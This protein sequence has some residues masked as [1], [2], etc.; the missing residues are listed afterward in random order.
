[1]EGRSFGNI[2]A[3]IIVSLST[4]KIPNHAG[5]CIS[6]TNFGLAVNFTASG[7][8]LN[9]KSD[10]F[11]DILSLSSAI[12]IFTFKG[13]LGLDSLLTVPGTSAQFLLPNSYWLF[14]A[15]HRCIFRSRRLVSSAG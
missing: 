3:V 2:S 12:L 8:L 5:I 1:M 11:F 13:L 10:I 9:G 14:Q 6:Y 4:V 7:C 15:A